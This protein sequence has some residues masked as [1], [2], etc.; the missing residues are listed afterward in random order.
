MRRLVP[1][2]VVVFLLA[3]GPA[4]HARPFTEH[5]IPLQDRLSELLEEF[6]EIPD[7]SLEKP[8]RRLRANY[9]RALKAF[10][11]DSKDLK[12]DLKILKAAG[13]HLGVPPVRWTPGD[14]DTAASGRRRLSNSMGDRSSMEECRR[15][16]L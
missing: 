8:G 15:C 9:R 7:V 2:L 14:Y 12:G 1:L 10:L 3:A 4:S 13:K 6:L 16:G 5:L 11:K